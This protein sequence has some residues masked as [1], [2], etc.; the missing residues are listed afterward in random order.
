MLIDVLR[1]IFGIVLVLSLDG[2]VAIIVYGHVEK[3]DL[4]ALNPIV[5]GIVALGMSFG[6]WAFGRNGEK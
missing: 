6:G 2:V 5:V 4:T 3:D 1:M